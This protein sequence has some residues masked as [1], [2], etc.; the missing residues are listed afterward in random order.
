MEYIDINHQLSI[1]YLNNIVQMNVETPQL[2]VF[3]VRYE[4]HKSMCYIE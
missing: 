4:R 2:N 3:L 1:T